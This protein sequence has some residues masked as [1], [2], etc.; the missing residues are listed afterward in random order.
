LK[1]QHSKRIYNQLDDRNSGENRVS[2]KS[3]NFRILIDGGD[4]QTDDSVERTQLLMHGI[5]I[6]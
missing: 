2:N 1:N 6:D 5:N 3:N 4:E